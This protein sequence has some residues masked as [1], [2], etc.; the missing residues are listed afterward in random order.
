[1]IT[2]MRAFE[3][4]RERAKNLPKEVLKWRPL[5]FAPYEDRDT[6]ADSIAK[7]AGFF[8][9]GGAVSSKTEFERLM[10]TNDLVDEF[11]LERTLLVANPVCRISICDQSGHERGCATGF[12]ISPRLLMTNEHVFGSGPEAACSIAEFNY[13]FDIAGRPETSYRFRL[14]PERF[15]F[16]NEKLD[17]AVVSVE[18]N[19][20]EGAV[21]LSKFGYLQLIPDTGKALLK[22]WMTI[23][24]HPG[25]SRRQFAIRENQCVNDKDPDVIWYVS[26]TAQGSSGSP[27]FNDSLQVVALHHSGVAQ[28]DAQKRYVLKDGKKTTNL[29]DVDDSE[30][31]WIA[32]AG[33]RISK[34]YPCL[35]REATDY[36][37]HIAEFLKTGDGGDILTRAYK[38]D[39]SDEGVIT[40]NERLKN[41]NGNGGSR[42]VLGTLV[43]ESTG[44]SL[45]NGLR[46][47]SVQPVTIHEA[48]TDV[49]LLPGTGVAFEA[50]KEPIIDHNYASREG[51]QKNFLGIETP[52]PTLTNPGLAAPMIGGGTRIPYEHFSIV[53]HKQRKLAIYTA[54]NVDGSSKAK[55]PD[56]SKDYSRKSLT[57]LGDHDTEKWVLDPRLDEKYQIPDEFYNKDK[58]A[59]DKGHIVRREDVCFGKDFAEVQRAN[60]DTF[61]CTNCSPQRSNFNRSSE[62]GKWGRFENYIGAQATHERY[63]LFAGPV[64]SPKDKVFPGT[65]RVQIPTMFWK[66]VCAVDNGKLQVFAFTLKQD[67]KGVPT[68][69]AVTVEWKQKQVTL[70]QLEK[71]IGLVK[72]PDVYHKA[73][74][75]KK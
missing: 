74:Q 68:E 14:K 7:R 67:L 12:M 55:Q 63:C 48:R 43:L 52:F 59:F 71:I 11:Y 61:H 72:F 45:G 18:E 8:T 25:G 75:A 3:A 19:S 32:N 15:F 24:Q 36:D 49:K 21:P 27:V 44:D 22:E 6:R 2:S 17:F 58:Q 40:M 54:S 16:N 10:G 50:A 35:V 5:D 57:G 9:R 30:V 53:L 69:F 28:Q 64:L 65:E 66:V 13:C 37:D 51:F 34:I 23:V 29:A 31:C 46:V 47:P 39:K 20:M 62:K 56:P 38:E 60:G 1:M 33:I 26:D 73:D 70:K 41:G 42:L 4:A